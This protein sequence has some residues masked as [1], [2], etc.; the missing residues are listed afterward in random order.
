MKK[1]ALYTLFAATALAGFF[2]SCD[3]VDFPYE[4]TGGSG[5][6]G[7][8]DWSLYPN[9]DSAH[10]AQNEWPSF[11]ANTNTL[12]NVLIEDFTGHRCSNCPNAANLL[13]N[14]EN[15][16]PNRVFGAALHTS[17][18]GITDFQ[19][20]NSAFPTVFYNDDA[21]AIGTFF[22]AI[23]GTTFQGNPHG[24]VNRI[25]TGSDNTS[26]AP[27][28]TS[29]TNTALATALKINMQSVANYFPS[30]R[31]LFIHTEIEKLD[32]SLSNELG[33]VI[34]L[35]EDSLVAP[36]LM[37]DQSTNQTYVHRDIMRACIG[38]IFGRTIKATDLDVNGSGKYYLN[39][40]Y[41]LPDVYTAEKM[42]LI[43]YV[44]DKTTYEIYQVIKQEVTD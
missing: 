39:A 9:G 24:A 26:P 41:R 12:R 30:T 19:E 22:G 6:T 7:E 8:L 2:A 16:N 38:G 36:Q 29:K 32:N 31:G 23:P 3:K 25:L 15:A 28:W 5:G 14:L 44:Y 13:H 1:F 21:I 40:S 33:Q 37:P 35:V 34:Y 20:T 18:L 4:Q 42:H 43:I 17:A 27:T 11:T 10:Y